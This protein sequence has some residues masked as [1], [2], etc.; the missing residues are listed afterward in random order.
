[1][2]TAILLPILA[3]LIGSCSFA[4]VS[5]KLFGLADPR[6]YGSGNPGATNVLRTG[7]KKAA[8]VTLLGDL[9]KGVIAVLLARG[10]GAD[11]NTLC[12]VAALVFLGHLYPVFLGFKGGKGVATA[13]GAILALAPWVGVAVLVIW[14]LMLAVFRYSSLS[15]ITAAVAA[16][17]LAFFL[18]EPLPAVG[19]IC[20][21]ALLLI[22]RHRGNLQKLVRGEEPRV[23]SKKNQK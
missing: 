17:I 14:L 7:N 15:A 12:L 5:A 23:G 21:M 20:L 13:A 11:E 18:G 22:A 8:M 1:M 19:A 3:Y 16:P 2:T 9:G 10:L 4:L 6:T